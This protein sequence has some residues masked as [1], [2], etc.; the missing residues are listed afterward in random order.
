MQDYP[1]H[2]KLFASRHLFALPALA[3]ALPLLFGRY[4][5]IPRGGALELGWNAAGGGALLCGQGLRIWAAGYMGRAGRSRRLKAATLLT[6]GSYAH[7][8]NPLYLNR[9]TLDGKCYAAWGRAY[10]ESSTVNRA[11]F[12]SHANTK[13]NSSS[14]V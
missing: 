14:V 2:E 12:C 8:R 3:I 6:T 13:S 5:H 10:T 7:V 9:S 4:G 1:T 11:R